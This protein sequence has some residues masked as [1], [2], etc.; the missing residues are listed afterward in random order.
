MKIGAPAMLVYLSCLGSLSL[1]FGHKPL[2]A[3]VVWGIGFC[4]ALRRH[5]D[6]DG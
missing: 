5:R 3:A 6:V 4:I 1:V 2:L